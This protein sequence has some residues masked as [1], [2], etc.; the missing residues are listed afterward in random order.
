MTPTD[1]GERI[2]AAVPRDLRDRL[3]AEAQREDRSVSSVLRQL[4]REHLPPLDSPATGD[5]AGREVST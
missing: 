3:F 4:I 1:A 2:A 5:T